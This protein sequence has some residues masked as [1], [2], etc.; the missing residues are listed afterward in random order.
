M[1]RLLPWTPALVWAALLFV[2]SS[3][4]SLPGPGVQHAD[5]AAHFAAYAVLGALLAFAAA[6]TGWPLA[7]AAALGILYGASDE[8]HQMFVPGRS[9]SVLDWLADVAGVLAAVYL[10]ARWRPGPRTT[11][12]SV[13]A[14]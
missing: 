14:A 6:R 11:D 1:K 12:H 13:L 9:A 10:Y 8:V 4:Q 7:V 3:R 5:K 2:L